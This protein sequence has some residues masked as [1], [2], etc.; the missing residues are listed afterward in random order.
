MIVDDKMPS[1]LV[2]LLRPC[3]RVIQ[4]VADWN[5]ETFELDYR[6]QSTDNIL[7]CISNPDGSATL[8][9]DIVNSM[10]TRNI[11]IALI[12]DNRTTQLLQTSMLVDY[13]CTEHDKDGILGLSP[14]FKLICSSSFIGYPPM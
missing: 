5:A 1:V 6:I 10:I 2:D 7:F 8:N 12:S 11:M 4:M 9:S 14:E 3:A 13:K